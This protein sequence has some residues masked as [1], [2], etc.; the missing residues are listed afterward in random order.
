MDSSCN[1]GGLEK[2]GKSFLGLTRQ[3]DGAPIPQNGK[4]TEAGEAMVWWTQQ[5]CVSVTSS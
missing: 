4:K 5:F 3:L 1:R 2:I